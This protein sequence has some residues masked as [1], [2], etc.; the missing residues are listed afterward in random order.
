MRRVG[1][2][3][4]SL[5]GGPIELSERRS[6]VRTSARHDLLRADRAVFSTFGQHGS[7]AVMIGS[8]WG[9]GL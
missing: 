1:V 5:N 4:L 3:G 7:V 6:E 8:G 2:V 9:L